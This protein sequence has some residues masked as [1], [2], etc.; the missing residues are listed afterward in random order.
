MNAMIPFNEFNNKHIYFN[1]PIENT[2]IK[3]S[4][5]IKLIYSNEILSMNGLFFHT[6]FMIFSTDYNFKKF[7][8]SYNL[9]TNREMLNK[10][11]NIER[12]IL[13]NYNCN[14][15]KKFN[16]YD[17]LSNGFIKIYNQDNDNYNV[18]KTKL[19]FILKISGVW[20]SNDEYGITYKLL[21]V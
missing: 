6:E 4:K 13:D 9:D 11:F 10:I 3:D 15:K 12:I 8:F 17:Y 1:E 16:L 18:R 7:R 19:G 5:F 20:E 14:K 21:L 2:I